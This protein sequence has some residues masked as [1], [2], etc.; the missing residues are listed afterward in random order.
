[1]KEHV[2]LT[3]FKW[4]SR[5]YKIEQVRG[6][7]ELRAEGDLIERTRGESLDDTNIFYFDF[8]NRYNEV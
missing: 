6:F 5:K 7:L 1:M 8:C 3:P 4:K 2:S